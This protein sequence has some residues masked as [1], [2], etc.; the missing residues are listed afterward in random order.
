VASSHPL[1]G[2]L[3]I[4]AADDD[5]S[6]LLS[7]VKDLD[8]HRLMIEELAESMGQLLDDMHVPPG[9]SVVTLRSVAHLGTLLTGRLPD[10]VGSLEALD[11]LK[12][13]LPTPA[14]GG[15]PHDASLSLIAE[16][17][18]ARPDYF[19]GCLGWLDQTGDAEFVLAIRGAALRAATCTIRAGAGIVAGSVPRGEAAETRSKLASVIETVAPASSSMLSRP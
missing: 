5:P 6:T 4:D 13:I 15:V 2:T 1:A 3:P 14:V 19:A 16:L 12:A 7:S 18:G 10:G 9:P 17:E 11:L 8:E